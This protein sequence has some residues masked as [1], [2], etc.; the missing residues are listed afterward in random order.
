M[1]EPMNTGLHDR[2][3]APSE[4]PPLP[5]APPPAPVQQISFPFLLQAHLG[6]SIE[7]LGQD[8]IIGRNFRM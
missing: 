3:P 2:L 8:L 6:A 4:I 7:G 5:A 1:Q